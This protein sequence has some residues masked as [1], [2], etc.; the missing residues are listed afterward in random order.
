MRGKLLKSNTANCSSSCSLCKVV[1]IAV[2]MM[3]RGSTFLSYSNRS[4]L[5]LLQYFYVSNIFSL[6]LLS[7]IFITRRAGGASNKGK[8]ANLGVAL[9]LLQLIFIFLISTIV[10]IWNPQKKAKGQRKGKELLNLPFSS[11]NWEVPLEALHF[12]CVFDAFDLIS[13]RVQQSNIF[14]L[15]SLYQRLAA[16]SWHGFWKASLVIKFIPHIIFI[17]HSWMWKSGL[18]KSSRVIQ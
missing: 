18:A 5:W 2:I 14:H 12:S 9:L 3:M 8:M 11:W 13:K 10:L 17:A 6:T 15:V 4:Y 1:V 7:H 16:L